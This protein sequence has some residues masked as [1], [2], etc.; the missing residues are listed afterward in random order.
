M[1]FVK[2]TISCLKPLVER[3]PVLASAYR[4]YRDQAELT[5]SPIESPWGFKLGGNDSMARGEFEPQETEVVRD[6][7]KDIDV[8]VN[9]GANVGYYCCHALSMGKQV[10]AFEPMQR[11]LIFLFQNIKINGWRDIEIF[12]LALSSEPDILNI[13]GAD[14]GASLVKGWAG[15][16][17]SYAALVPASTLDLVLGDRL[18]GK[19]I[20]I[21]MDVEGA[22]FE[23]IKGAIS[24]LRLDPR[25]IW[26]IEISSSEHQPHG[27]VINPNFANT[28]KLMLDAGY[29][30][31]TA[32]DVKREVTISDIEAVQ[33]GD[34]KRFS[35]HNFLFR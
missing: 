4:N 35:T 15:I 9:I 25:P 3:Y 33:A 6:L 22:E 12:P 5:R 13:Y 26:M 16:P 18:R 30:A 29:K 23:V 31:F 24:F 21:L 2:K 11:N 8:L 28:F 27:V 17:E 1:S 10:I 14:T 20:L 19:R 32:D 7:L 34:V